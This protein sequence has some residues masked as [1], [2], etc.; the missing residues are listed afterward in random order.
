MGRGSWTLSVDRFSESSAREVYTAVATLRSDLEIRVA[1]VEVRD[2]DSSCTVRCGGTE[3]IQ[4]EISLL[5]PL[6]VC[7]VARDA[8]PSVSR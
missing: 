3:Q 1:Q 7:P 5:R 8:K 6:A 2:N 4:V